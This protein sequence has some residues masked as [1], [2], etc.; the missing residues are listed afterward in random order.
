LDLKTLLKKYRYEHG[1]TQER[2]SEILG[3]DVTTVSRWERGVTKPSPTTHAKLLALCRPRA[4][5][6]W[7]LRRIIET[8]P[9]M[10]QL[11]LPNTM[12]L[13]ASLEFQKLQKMSA[14][15][16][17]GL[18]DIKDFPPELVA[19]HEVFGGVEQ[20]FINAQTSRGIHDWLAS[21]PTNKSGEDVMLQFASQRVIL[22][23]SSCAIVSTSRVVGPQ[24]RIPFQVEW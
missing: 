7:Q 9:T 22:D 4:G 21:A 11:F 5:I 3:T 8:T 17:V 6:D 2:L 18:L 16:V 10:M 24:D 15:D 19:E 23:D 1:L 12:V 20:V 14:S 13:A